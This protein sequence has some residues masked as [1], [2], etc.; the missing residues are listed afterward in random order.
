MTDGFKMIIFLPWCLYIICEIICN[1]YFDS[2]CDQVDSYGEIF[3]QQ[4]GTPMDELTAT[5]ACTPGD[6][7]DNFIIPARVK[8][9]LHMWMSQLQENI[10]KLPN[11]ESD[12]KCAKVIKLGKGMI[13]SIILAII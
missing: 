1:N 9:H 2:Y 3:Y 5:K 6:W 8:S 10:D 4:Y 7:G 12:R 11:T 13:I